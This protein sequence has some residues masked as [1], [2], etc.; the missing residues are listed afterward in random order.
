[1]ILSFIEVKNLT[2]IFRENGE[3]KTEKIALDNINLKIDK[4]E[5]IA[6]IGVNGSGKSTLAKHFN[7]LLLP[8]E[9]QCIVDGMKVDD[10]EDIWKVRQK[11]SMVFQNPDNQIIATVVE[12]DIAFGPENMGLEREE[13]RNRIEFALKSLHIEHLRKMPP[14]L[15]SGG[16]KQLTAIAGAIAMR[17]QCIVLDEPTAMLDPQGRNAVMKALKELHEKY[18]I[19]IIMIT[20]FMEEAVQAN[21]IIVMDEGKI[22]QDGAAK[23]IFKEKDKLK[24]IGLN[25]PLAVDIVDALQKKGLKI[26]DV[27]DNENLAKELRKLI[28]K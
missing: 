25:V 3:K 22:I 19:T 10:N 21:R 4:G 5:F 27:F 1:M 17:T 8:S 11:V 16:Q 24:K 12:D 9:G 18:N 20:H 15:L 7:G 23:D 2:H 28:C 13:I 6:I 14:H 26:A